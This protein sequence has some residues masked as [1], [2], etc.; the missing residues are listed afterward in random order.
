[1]PQGERLNPVLQRGA[2]TEANP[3]QTLAQELAPYQQT[4]ISDLNSGNYSGALQA[5]IDSGKLYNTN[6]NSV[7]T[8]PLLADLET[9]SGLQQLD[10]TKTWTPTDIQNYYNAFNTNSTF[11]GTSGESLGKNP[12]GTWG[13]GAHVANGSDAAANIAAQGDNSAPDLARF[14]GARPTQS[15]LQKWGAPLVAAASAVL[16][17]EALPALAGVLGGGTAAA[18][19]AGALYGAGTGALGA[20]VS[21]GNIGKSALLGGVGGGIGGGLAATGATSGAESALTDVAGVPQPIANGVVQGAEGAGIG[22]LKSAIAGGNVGQGALLGGATGAIQGGV[23]GAISTATNQAPISPWTNAITGAASGILANN[24]VGKY[25]PNGSAA[26]S[27]ATQSPAAGSTS[28]STAA[29]SSTS[30]IGPYNFT[31]MGYQ[32]MQQANPN[33]QNYNTY[34]QGPEASFFQPVPGT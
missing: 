25:S 20:G 23:Q 16:A 11:H 14:V 3:Q 6:Y 27:A 26:P 24:L 4:A 5:G 10:P 34:G 21:G 12:Y 8:D 32:P 17:P 22:A 9:S 29:G 18:V 19:G 13:D 30:N 1:M 7:T 15:F 33:I 2:A 28:G 31:G